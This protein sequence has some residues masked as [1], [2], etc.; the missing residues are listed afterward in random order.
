VIGK[1]L[2]LEVELERLAKVLQG[3]LHAV[4]LARDL[5]LQ[6]ARDVPGRFLGDGGGESHGSEST[7]RH[8]PSLWTPTA[9]K[10]LQASPLHEHGHRIVTHRDPVAHC[11]LCVDPWRS[12]GASRG[13]V[14]LADHV[15]QPDVAD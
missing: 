3:F 13:G 7:V 8:H 14:D 15:A 5:D 4:A 2:I 12:I 6:A 1:G 9:G 11:E 10:T